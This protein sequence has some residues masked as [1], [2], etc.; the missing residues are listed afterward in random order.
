MAL[1]TGRPGINPGPATHCLWSLLF[2]WGQCS[3]IVVDLCVV[4]VEKS[5]ITKHPGEDSD[6]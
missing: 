3:N 2:V 6:F 5:A 4:E 1:E